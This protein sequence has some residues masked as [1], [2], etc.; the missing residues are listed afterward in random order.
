MDNRR[1]SIYLPINNNHN[2]DDEENNFLQSLPSK[3]NH[4]NMDFDDDNYDD[5]DVV[6]DDDGHDQQEFHSN[7]E[8]VFGNNKEN[9]AFK[10]PPRLAARLLGNKKTK[11]LHNGKIL[12]NIADNDVLV[13]DNDEIDRR[14]TMLIRTN[15]NK[16]DN[17]ETASVSSLDSISD[18]ISTKSMPMY[19]DDS[20]YVTWINSVLTTSFM[21]EN[22]TVDTARIINDCVISESANYKG[23]TNLKI[24]QAPVFKDGITSIAYREQQLMDKLRQKAA[25]FFQC[26]QITNAKDALLEDIKLARF[27]IRKDRSIHMDVG[28]KKHIL[29]VLLN[30]N[31]LWLKIALETIFNERINDHSKNEV[32]TLV[33]FLTEHLLS[34]KKI[35]KRKNKNLTTYFMNENNVKTA[36][37]HILYHYIMIVHFLDVAKR[38]RLIDHDPCLFRNIAVCKSSRD[39]IISFSREYITGVGDIT[40]SL[41]NVGIH[42]EHVQQPIEEFNFTASILSKDLRCG[43]R[44]ARILETIFQRNDILPSLFYPSNNTTRKLHNM[45]IVFG[46][47][48]KTGIDLNCNGQVISPR[49]ICLGNRNKTIC[50]LDRLM[51]IFELR[52]REIEYQRSIDKIIKIQRFFRRWFATQQE[53]SLF[54]RKKAA[55]IILQQVFPS[56]T[57]QRY[58]RGYHDQKLYQTKRKMTILVQRRFRANQEMKKC[59]KQF[60]RQRQ[61]VITIQ[62]A[63]RS[64]RLTQVCRQSFLSK[65]HAS[66]TIQ[67]YWR[68][69]HQH[70]LY[71]T[72]R[73]MAIMVQHRFRANQEMKKC[74]KQ[75][76]LQRQSTIAIQRAFRSYRLTRYYRKEFLNKKQASVTIQKYWRGYHDQKLYQTKRKMTIIVQRRFRANQEMKKCCKQYQLQRQSAIAIQRAF[77]SYR[78]TRECRLKFLDKKQASITIQRYWRGY[79]QHILYQTKRK[80]VLIVQRR[81]RANQE[82]KKCRKQFQLQR[83]SVITIQRAF[84]SYRLTKECRQS[85]LSK[86]QASITIQR[87]WRGYHERNL[88]QT[89]RKMTIMVQRRFRANQE[90]K[91]CLKQFQLQR[92]SVIMIQRTFRSY[93]ETRDYRRQ[94]VMMRQSSIVLQRYW[95]GYYQRKCFLKLKQNI[96][97]IQNRF[98]ANQLMKLNYRYFQQLKTATIFVQKRFRQNRQFKIDYND[99]QLKRKSTII[100]Q[101]YWRGYYERQR[102]LKLKQMVIF[103]QNQF[104]ANQL[105]KLNYRYFQQL[106]TATIFVQKRFRQNRQYK[107]DYNDYQ[108]KRNSTIIIQNWFRN[109]KHQKLYK[110]WQTIVRNAVEQDKQKRKNA[111][112]IIQKIWRGHRV[113]RELMDEFQLIRDRLDYANQT[114]TENKKLINI[115]E[116][117]IDRFRT[118]VNIESVRRELETL[119]MATTYSTEICQIIAHTEWFVHTLINSFDLFNRSEPHKKLIGHILG[120]LM[121][122]LIRANSKF[123]YNEIVLQVMIRL[124]RNFPRSESILFRSL[125]ILNVLLQNRQIFHCYKRNKHWIQVL[126]A[127][128]KKNDPKIQASKTRSVSQLRTKRFS[129]L[130]LS[131]PVDKYTLSMICSDLSKIIL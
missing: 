76:Q 117:S 120:I 2:N 116:K 35:A 44:L 34:F 55:V 14:Q 121:N 64:Y 82:M 84:R 39:I 12:P 89:K 86:K 4:E 24:N 62:R 99:Y 107:I 112:I 78:L 25:K 13:E 45:E 31:P 3:I 105:M 33:Q 26:D 68:G 81:F 41:R 73:K 98:R 74:R 1:I 49:D 113:R 83:Q 20:R 115:I 103:I 37:E 114:A 79:H 101:R 118:A 128:V 127:I 130:L 21:I 80:M 8:F 32:R 110:N 5:V 71:Q 30:Y 109:C 69:Y 56:V 19:P 102:F 106:K 97:F 7:I 11:S 47:L 58:W 6:D 88:Y 124:L 42:L 22:I 60:Q 36:K 87:Y 18:D 125:Y 23:S 94:F 29:E 67:R 93:I 131:N 92:Q 126:E 38:N 72:K 53:R 40:K 70:K 57:I 17:I 108:L 63:F 90:M 15:K 123:L 50:L 51:E 100:I 46:M 27:F 28:S 96:I 48:R 75:F 91:R 85:F 119:E 77:R 122:L 54:L 66:I 52:Q 10:L 9:N 16:H 129:S 59:C 95:R 61:S 111:A 104:R 43:L 65:K